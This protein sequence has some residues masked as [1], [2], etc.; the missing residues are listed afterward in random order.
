[1]TQ[2]N[3]S[4]QEIIDMINVLQDEESQKANTK[5]NFERFI[6]K[7]MKSLQAIQNDI[8]VASNLWT[9]MNRTVRVYSRSPMVVS[10]D[11]S[12]I[13]YDNLYEA[14]KAQPD[15]II[16]KIEAFGIFSINIYIK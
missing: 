6:D 5:Y 1:M 15:A 14:I 13:E 11:F 3:Y 9:N 2:T 8:K 16:D 4:G 7:K 10:D 12:M